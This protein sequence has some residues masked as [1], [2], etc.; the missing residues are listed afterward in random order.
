MIRCHIYN[1]FVFFYPFCLIND[2]V[3]I[4]NIGRLIFHR[5][6]RI[7]V[8]LISFN[9]INLRFDERHGEEFESPKTTQSNLHKY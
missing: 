7:D 6:T 5:Y 2:I 8:C 3:F 1:V 4:I 9:Y